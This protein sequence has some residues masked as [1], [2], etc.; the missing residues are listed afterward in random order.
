MR[1]AEIFEIWRA[2]HGSAFVTINQLSPMVKVLIDPDN[3]SRQN[4]YSRLRRYI[5]LARFGDLVLVR[6]KPEGYWSAAT[7]AVLKADTEID[8]AATLFSPRTCF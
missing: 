8:A 7:Y 3:Q 2:E 1:L 4:I 5:N 6:H